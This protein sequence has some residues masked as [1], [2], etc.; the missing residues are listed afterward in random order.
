VSSSAP[1]NPY[2]ALT[3]QQIALLG[4]A[5]PTGP[6]AQLPFSLGAPFIT[7]SLGKYVKQLRSSSTVGADP[8]S[9]YVLTGTKSF[10]NQTDWNPTKGTSVQSQLDLLPGQKNR[11]FQSLTSMMNQFESW[12]T[13]K[14][15]HMGKLL[16]MGGYLGGSGSTPE[17]AFKSATLQD[18]TN[19][20]GDLLNDAAARFAAGKNQTPDQL[21]EMNIRFNMAQAGIDVE[22]QDFNKGTTESWWNKINASL[23]PDPN[24]PNSPNFTGTK[25]QTSKH[26]D[27]YSPE[28]TKGLVRAIL[29]QE[30]GRD[31]TQAEMEDFSS[32]LTHS[33]RAN[34]TTSKSTAVYKDGQ[35][36][37]ENTTTH[38]G[39]GSA[40]LQEV[41]TQ[42]A[43]SQPGWAE[44]QAVGTYLPAL[45][46]ALGS[47][48][49]GT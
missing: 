35:L 10:P 4:G 9:A 44:W 11:D 8:R 2:S 37:N 28:D 5:G 49:P 42:R 33:M 15:Q 26:V 18:I 21:L 30:M 25:T 43:Q 34:P 22:G 27:I 39:I 23:S 14:K 16:F 40:G 20:Y 24:D 31:P 29:H 13:E 3:P 32:A 38:Q 45:F 36:V 19:A 17:E 7:L 1:E 41:A 12:S 6:A 48:V 46:S 47:S